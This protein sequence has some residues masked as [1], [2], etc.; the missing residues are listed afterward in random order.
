MPSSPDAPGLFFDLSIIP[1][2]PEPPSA[3]FKQ[4][5]SWEAALENVDWGKLKNTFK[6]LSMGPPDE[7]L[8]AGSITEHEDGRVLIHFA[9][10]HAGEF[11]EFPNI[12]RRSIVWTATRL[13]DGTCFL[14]SVVSIS[15]HGRSWPSFGGERR[16]EYEEER[17]VDSSGRERVA[18]TNERFEGLLVR[19]RHR[20]AINRVENAGFYCE[21]PSWAP[22]PRS[23]DEVVY[24]TWDEAV[25]HGKMD[26]LDEEGLFFLT[27]LPGHCNEVALMVVGGVFVHYQVFT[28]N[29]ERTAWEPGGHFT[30][31]GPFDAD[32][33][34]IGIQQVKSG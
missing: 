22:K 1:K 28:A 7:D 20:C 2:N 34:L 9:H 27:R 30:L 25:N 17:S 29:L 32:A 10:I 18:I 19:A 15:R 4:E 11:G 23:P 13:P 5:T 3:D 31:T 26:V 16:L 8:R 33:V 14:S 24:L 21:P 12:E 6:S